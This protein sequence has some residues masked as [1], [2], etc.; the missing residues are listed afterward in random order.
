[1]NLN[2]YKIIF[3]L[4]V[5]AGT[6]QAQRYVDEMFGVNVTTD[7]VYA[8]N[9]SVLS[10][11]PSEIPL[12]MDIYTPDGDTETDRPLVLYFHT[13]SFLP[14][15]FNG[16]ITGSRRDS[17]VVE[18]SKRLARRGYVVA[19]V[20]YRQGWRPDA[21]GPAG[22]NIR[23]GTL[24]N[25]S[26]RGIQDAR[27]C[28]RFFQNTIENEANPW[29]VS[30]DRIV[31]WG[32]GTGGY[33][34]LGAGY[35][36]R[37]EEL[38]LEK[39]TDTDTAENYIN[40]ALSSDVYGSTDTDLNIANNVGFSTDV[41]MVVNMGGAL[42]DISWMDGQDNEPVL[43]GF[44]C[45]RDPFAP[46]ADGP[47]IVPTTGDFVVNVSGT[48]TAVTKANGEGGP[49]LNAPMAA[50]ATQPFSNPQIEGRNNAY[51]QIPIDYQGQMINLSTSHMYPFISD[52]F[53]SG[54]W[55]WHDQATLEQIVA[56]TNAAAGTS[57]DAEVLNNNAMLT[58]PNLSRETG[59]AYI[60]TIMQ[61]FIPRAY[62][63]LQLET[64]NVNETPLIEAGLTLSPNPASTSVQV[65]TDG[66]YEMID[67]GV[68]DM[69][70]K[71]V[72]FYVGINTNQHTIERK[73]LAPGMYLV[74][75]RFE[76]GVQAHKILFK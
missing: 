13:G 41:A 35:L 16:G 62:L 27:A 69:T 40:E 50:A 17:S 1:M 47:V 6:L 53:L 15:L 2:R 42:G 34:S 11:M 43:V 56:G 44:H 20:T 39:F 61:F 71:L 25:A 4:L 70:G 29:G 38:L 76:E 14:P 3:M 75:A 36:D 68:Y 22:Q 21:V 45:L 7:V 32:Q 51:S 63:A 66:E 74:K 67:I 58:N 26:Y 5:F 12:V 72:Q 57:F 24:L 8:N 33:L 52:G 37:N 54:P 46:F 59:M 55:D 19:S 23:T 18:I 31:L 28:V 64:V 10:G 65:N 9:I 48:H 49:D 60:D 30:P 73:S